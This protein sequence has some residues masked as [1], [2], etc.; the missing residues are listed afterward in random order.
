MTAAKRKR[1]A[2]ATDECESGCREREVQVQSS[3]SHNNLPMLA[4]HHYKQGMFMYSISDR[5]LHK[6]LDHYG[7]LSLDTKLYWSTPQGWML[8]MEHHPSRD[9]PSAAYLWN[10]SNG[11]EL[12]LPK[13]QEDH[14][15]SPIWRC[16]LS[17]KDP[18]HPGCVVVLV[19]SGEPA[20]WYCHTAGGGQW[21][22]RSH[23]IP[24]RIFTVASC[25][26]KLHF[27]NSRERIGTIDFP[28]TPPAAAD[29]DDQQQHPVIQYFD[30][31]A[32]EFPN[33]MDSANSWL[34]ESHDQLFRVSIFFVGDDLGAVHVYK[35]DFSARAWRR[36][37]D[38]GDVVVF[39]EGY[40]DLAASCA[41]SCLGLKA[42]QIYFINS[43]CRDDGGY[44]YTFDLELDI[45]ESI[46][47]PRPQTLRCLLPFWIVPPGS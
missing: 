43:F 32:I 6:N 37:R 18:S 1:V 33:G 8:I 41:A 40:S 44:L 30:V 26:A 39:L 24:T 23:E 22:R 34:V 9:K 14:R 17:H 15:L 7:H 20:V 16:L 3:S 29:D 38:I 13:V 10:P 25:G 28:S 19:C 27:I 31:P 12:P 11:D 35:M 36:V 42:N 5:I 45:L 47:V 4:F 2:A 21:T 46:W